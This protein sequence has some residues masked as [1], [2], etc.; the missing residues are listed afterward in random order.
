MQLKQGVCAPR[1]SALGP[2]PLPSTLGSSAL[3]PPKL[4][5]YTYRCSK[6]Y[7]ER[8]SYGVQNKWEGFSSQ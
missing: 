8:P 4:K 2:N 1:P 7:L 3:G 5:H 6:S